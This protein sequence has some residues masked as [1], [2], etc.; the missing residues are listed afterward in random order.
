MV[1]CIFS[2]LLYL[3]LLLPESKADNRQLPFFSINTRNTYVKGKCSK[4]I[5]AD[6]L[7]KTNNVAQKPH[8]IKPIMDK[9][10]IL[11]SIANSKFNFIR[12]ETIRCCK[13]MIHL[14]QRDKIYDIKLFRSHVNHEIL[15][16]LYNALPS[17]SLP[18]MENR[19][20]GESFINAYDHSSLVNR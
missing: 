3:L 20:R 5:V 18:N 8:L 16:Y 1:L 17:Q 15:H 10:N 14:Q 4:S 12:R 13:T 9:A 6:D 7:I 11:S 19:L 2:Y